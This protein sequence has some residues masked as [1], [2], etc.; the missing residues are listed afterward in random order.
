MEAQ[1]EVG[2]YRLLETIRQYARERL[3]ET[4]EERELRGRHRDYFLALAEEADVYGPEQGA[5]LERLEAEHDNLRAALEWCQTQ[6]AGVEA[7]LRLA[8]ALWWFWL[9]RAYFSEGRAYLAAVL[10]RQGAAERTQLRANAL[11]AAGLL[12]HEQGDYA[13]ARPLIEQSLAIFQELGDKRRIALS[14]YSLGRVALV[15]GEYGAAKPL[16]EQSLAILR[17]VGPGFGLTLTNLGVVA[18][19]QGEYRA[20]RALLEESLALGR[21]E[22][23]TFGIACALYHLGNVAFREGEYASARAL[24]EESLA[25]DEESG[26]KVGIAETLEA[27][28]RVGVVAGQSERAARLLG[29]AACVREA[30]GAPVR[31]FDREEYERAMAAVREALGEEAFASAWAQGRAMPL[32]QAIEYALE[33]PTRDLLQ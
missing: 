24:L 3:A 9:I 16:F 20:A 33:E 30:I 25:I 1:G 13:A 31:P 15:Q 21:E 29:A 28:T 22:G 18:Y 12:A 11:R 32:E 2:R 26:D 23:D 19:K 27:L 5:C 4:E 14:L 10:T 6:E 8:A 17:E 7:G